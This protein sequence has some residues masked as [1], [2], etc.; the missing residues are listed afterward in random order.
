VRRD[1]IMRRSGRVGFCGA[2]R[3]HA[4]HDNLV[5]ARFSDENGG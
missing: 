3:V 1:R 2:F 4:A 5:P